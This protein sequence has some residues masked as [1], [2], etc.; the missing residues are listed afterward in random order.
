MCIC[1]IASQVKFAVIFKILKFS[2]NW[3]NLELWNSF[4]LHI[5]YLKQCTA[6]ACSHLSV[7]SQLPKSMC[8]IWIPSRILHSFKNH[9]YK[10]YSKTLNTFGMQTNRNVSC[11]SIISSI[12]FF[13]YFGLQFDYLIFTLVNMPS[14]VIV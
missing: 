3:F 9:T 13:Q 4:I 11:T 14:Q 1:F 7:H 10:V 6:H 2:R 8:K 5:T 12:F